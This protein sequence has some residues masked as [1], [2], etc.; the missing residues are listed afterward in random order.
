MKRAKILE[1]GKVEKSLLIEF[2]R[3]LSDLH[4]E[5]KKE[6]R[7]FTDVRSK[8]EEDISYL[9]GGNFDEVKVFESIFLVTDEVLSISIVIFTKKLKELESSFVGTDASKTMDL[10]I[11]SFRFKNIFT[12][13]IFLISFVEIVVINGSD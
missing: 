3:N 11:S 12:P 8:E 2:Y 13:D 10:L 7:D 4:N 5:V 6:E 9:F 1:E